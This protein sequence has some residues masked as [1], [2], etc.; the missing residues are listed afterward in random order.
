MGNQKS[1]KCI[2]PVLVSILDSL[3]LSL[4]SELENELL[5]VKCLQLF[6]SLIKVCSND[7]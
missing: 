5:K 4:D 6:R 1:E 3:G 2:N 7:I